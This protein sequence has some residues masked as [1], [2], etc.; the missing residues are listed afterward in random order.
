MNIGIIGPLDSCEKIATA[1]REDFPGLTPKIYEVSRTE[2]AYIEKERYERECDG[3]IFTGMGVY[4][5]TIEKVDITLPHVYIPFL[6]SS[7]M[8]AFWE[9]KNKFPEC[10]NISIDIVD[11]TEVE[12]VLEE[13]NLNDINIQTMEFNHLYPE[14]KYVDFHLEAQK[15]NK[16]CI[17]ITGL[18][19]VFEQVSNLGYP[20]IRLYSTKSSIRN[21]IKDL[22]YRINEVM[23]KYSNLAVQVI[24]IEGPEDVSRYR[25]I[26]ISS[27]V[28]I[29][30]IGYLKEI[31]GSIFNLS[32][33]KYLIFSTRGAVENNQNLQRLKDILDYVKKEDLKVFVGTGLGATAHE[34]EINANKALSAAKN[35]GESC[36]FKVEDKRIE[37]PLLDEVELSYNFIM[38][39]EEI[40][41]M[42]EKID[43]S[44]IYIQKIN[45][46]KEK[47]GKDTFTSDELSQYL[48]VSVRTANRIIK[49]VLDNNLGEEIGLE[50]NKSV[51]RPKKIIR[52]NFNI[53]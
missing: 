25:R 4:Y 34:S 9:L 53:S 3:L 51:G 48:D 6:T 15:Q 13:F 5:K 50:T 8:K 21:T 2:E 31:Q 19:W 29:N 11:R 27:F 52:I 1:I 14:Q 22:I 38:D 40:D 18:G 12:D 46:I 47:Y 37:G 30:L 42:S 16:A 45:S 17:A 28:S 26:E 32:W 41:K 20:T 10:K 49:K 44:P 7:I 36:I 24:Y 33:N 35:L 39:S 23:V 43:L